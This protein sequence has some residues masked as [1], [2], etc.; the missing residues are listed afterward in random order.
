MLQRLGNIFEIIIDIDCRVTF[1]E[2]QCGFR[3]LGKLIARMCGL[4]T[5]F[6]RIEQ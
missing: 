3:Y 2:C 5:E 6:I 4:I 1:D